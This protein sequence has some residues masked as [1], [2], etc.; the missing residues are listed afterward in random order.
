MVYDFETLVPAVGLDA[1]MY[2]NLKAKGICDEDSVCY[3]VAEMKFKLLPEIQSA[4][5]KVVSDGTLGYSGADDKYN[6]AVCKWMK[7]RHGFIVEP[8][9][10]VQS[11][12][13]V[14]ALGVAIRAYTN[15]GDGIIIQTPVYNPFKDQILKNNRV[16]LENPLKKSGESYEIDFDDFEKK[17]AC[18]NTKMF[19]L[20]SPHNPVGRVWNEWELKKI[21]EICLKNNV[22]VVSDEIHSDITFKKKHITYA[23]ISENAEQNSVICTAPSKTFNIPGLLTSNIII[24]NHKLKER[25]EKQAEISFGHYINPIGAAAAAAAYEYGG[26]W[27]DELCGYIAE[28]SLYLKKLLNDK[29][30]DAVMTDMEGT[31][32]A[33]IDFSFLGLNEKE[34]HDFFIKDC[35][36]NVNFGKMYGENGKGHIRMNIGCPRRYIDIAVD[37]IASKIKTKS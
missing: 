33:W 28:N 16:V 26:A 34:L 21:S 25:F 14:T 18:E 35:R 3:G 24:K 30:P 29:I 10:M 20:C 19:I 13:V 4:I 1:P 37:K 23:K 8:C 36:L 12:G 32:L 31:Y 27:V 6:K 22:L 15:E 7:E 11:Y 17:A 2:R 9:D 5:N